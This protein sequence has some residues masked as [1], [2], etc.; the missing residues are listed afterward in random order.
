M[1]AL[2][3]A[4]LSLAAMLVGLAAASACAHKAVP[5]VAPAAASSKVNEKDCS[6]FANPSSEPVFVIDGVVLRGGA[7]S[8]S[9]AARDSARIA[10]TGLHYQMI[11]IF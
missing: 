6:R 2:W 9:P 8:L 11:R 5:Q 10:C 1:R 7:D 4:A 3:K